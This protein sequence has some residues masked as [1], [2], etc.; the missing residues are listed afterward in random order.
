MGFVSG[1]L[2]G[3][4][5]RQYDYRSLLDHF[6][7]DAAELN[8]P[9]ARVS[10]A[11]YVNLYNRTVEHL[12]DE[13]FALFPR[14]VG[15]GFFEF[16][17]RGLMGSG[18]LQQALAR[19]QRYLALLLPE[20]RL[21]VSRRRGTAELVISESVSIW[22]DRNDPRR[23]FAYEWL[24]RLIHGISC[25]LAARE[26]HL[27]SVTFP[28]SRPRHAAD[29]VLIYTPRSHFSGSRLVATFNPNLLDLPVR[30]NEMELAEFLVDAPGKITML[31]RRDREFVRQVRDAIAE[32][33]P[34]ISGLR[35]I[36]AHMRMSPRTLHRRLQAEGSSYGAIRDALRRDIALSRLE[37]TRDSIARIAEELGYAEPSAFFRAVQGWTGMAP[38]QYRRKYLV[39]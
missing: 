18:T 25:W 20:I 6:G 34:A 24:L 30:R 33:L 19:M 21:E 17:C 37:K 32:S 3:M 36:S 7:I 2:S 22:Q 23:I 14:P 31:Y 11:A 39:Q 1:L 9:Q 4:A 16:L 13:G 12:G 15:P 35:E 10:L 29:Y 38:T 28:Y 8:L 27:A 5:S 26:L